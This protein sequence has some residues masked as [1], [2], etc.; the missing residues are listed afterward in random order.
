MTALTLTSAGGTAAIKS[1]YYDEL[2]L[3]VAESQL[4]H[5]QLGQLN[6]QIAAGEGGYGSNVLFWTRFVNLSTVTSGSG[7]GVATSACIISA[8]Q[9][10]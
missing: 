4:V 2:F 10:T 6:R 8:V 5:K 3:K 9:V 7:E 1:R